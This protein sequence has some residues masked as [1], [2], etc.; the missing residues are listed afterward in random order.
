MQKFKISPAIQQEAETLL[1]GTGKD[2]RKLDKI[3]DDIEPAIRSAPVLLKKYI[4]QNARIIGFNVD[5]EFNQALDGLMI[6]D[7]RNVN[8]STIENLQKAIQL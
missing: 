6:L 5:P 7:F 8:R 4:Q 2:L 1:K 3:I